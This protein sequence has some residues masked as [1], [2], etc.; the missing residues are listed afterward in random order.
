M[1]FFKCI[2]GLLSE[3]VLA[4][5]MLTSPKRSLNLQKSTF[6][7]LFLHSERNCVKKSY[8]QSHLKFNDWL[9]TRCPETTSILVVIETIYSYQLY[10]II[11]KTIGFFAIFFYHF[12][13]LYEISD[14]TLTRNYEYSRSNR[15]NL[16]LPIEIK[17]SKKAI[18]FWLYFF[19]IFGI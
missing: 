9:I 6:I 19:C 13:Y 7:L 16:Q 4:V 15:E 18:G 12:W 17:L 3:N 1:S 8:F 10:Q 14:N 5:N 11:C 2:T